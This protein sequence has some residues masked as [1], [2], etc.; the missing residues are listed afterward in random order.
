VLGGLAWT[1]WASGDFNLSAK[2][3]LE[4]EKLDGQV[5]DS[6]L[7]SSRYVDAHLAIERE[8]YELAFQRL[9]YLTDHWVGVVQFYPIQLLIHAFGILAEAQGQYRRAA[10]LFGAQDFIARNLMNISTPSER[11]RYAAA[12]ASTRAALGETEFTAAFAEGKA[13]NLE[14]AIAYVRTA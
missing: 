4:A 13:M 11:E 7:S 6:I 9:N 12:L 1:A 5:S 14:Q 10:V 3:C 2:Y 8:E